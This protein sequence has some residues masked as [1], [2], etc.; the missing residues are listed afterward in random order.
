MHHV[1][2]YMGEVE[3][4]L[5]T[6]QEEP[7]YARI[8]SNLD[9]DVARELYHHLWEVA[10]DRT[11][12]YNGE[13]EMFKRMTGRQVE[14]AEVLQWYTQEGLLNRVEKNGEIAFVPAES[15]Q[16]SIQGDADSYVALVDE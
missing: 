13:R 4:E 1:A 3:I 16:K 10:T 6:N 8:V 2:G 14:V 15:V 7:D 9:D 5:W 12:E 11:Q